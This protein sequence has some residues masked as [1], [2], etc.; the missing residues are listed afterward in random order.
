MSGLY[1]RIKRLYNN[2]ALTVDGV[3]KAYKDGMITREEFAKITMHD[4]LEMEKAE[5]GNEHDD[6]QNPTE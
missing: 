3:W 4:P 6:L 5:G 2:G 1:T